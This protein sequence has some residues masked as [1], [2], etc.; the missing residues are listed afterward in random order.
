MTISSVILQTMNL[1]SYLTRVEDM[2]SQGRGDGIILK[3][4][5]FL[6]KYIESGDLQSRYI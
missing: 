4:V 3:T 2:V 1:C 5:Y 6:E